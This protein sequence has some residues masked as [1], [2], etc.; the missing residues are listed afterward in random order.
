MKTYARIDSDKVVELFDTTGDIK[1]MFHPDLVW[2]DGAGARIGDSYQDGVF[3]PPTPEQPTAE[4]KIQAAESAV[5]ALLDASAK[6]KG[7]DDIQSASQYAAL[8]IG[9]PFQAEG[10]AFLLWRAKCWK[11][12]YEI[13]DA[14]NKKTR[15]E[16]TPAELITAMPA[17]LL[18]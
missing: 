6:A 8:P 16:P 13:L 1:K 15:A 3:T 17:L 9:E 5:Q 14:V 7:Y 12:C 18:P 10:A 4:Q 2:V 11:K